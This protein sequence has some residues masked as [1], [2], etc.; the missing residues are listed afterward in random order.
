MATT[1]QQLSPEQ[2]RALQQDTNRRYQAYLSLATQAGNAVKPYEQAD[3]RQRI[4]QQV[5]YQNYIPAREINRFGNQFWAVEGGYT[6]QKMQQVRGYFDQVFE[7]Q[8]SKSIPAEEEAKILR[9]ADAQYTQETGKTQVDRESLLWKTYRN[10]RATEK[11][12]DLWKQF[13]NDLSKAETVIM[14]TVVGSKDPNLGSN[15]LNRPSQVPTLDVP[16]H[17]GHSQQQRFDPNK[18]QLSPTPALHV[19]SHTG[20][21]NAEKP[22]VTHVFESRRN[23]QDHE[24]AGGHTVERHVGKSD[25]SLRSRLASDPN[26]PAAS[27][28]RNKEAANRADGQFVKQNKDAINKWLQSKTN[29][30]FVGTIIMPQSIGTVIKRDGSKIESHNVEV[31]IVRDSSAQGWHVLTSYPVAE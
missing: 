27:T 6:P 23:L 7:G 8:Y 21:T 25:S 13:S 18:S 19:P 20:H 4:E 26:I 31:V 24:A 30:P 2:K 10:I 3:I 14:P 5:L 11:F 12:P 16:T 1:V 22:A 17:T 28:F 15:A 9:S 29:K